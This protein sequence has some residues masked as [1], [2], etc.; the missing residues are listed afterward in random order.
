MASFH[1]AL[2]VA[3]WL[4]QLTPI[5]ALSSAVQQIKLFAHPKLGRVL[6]IGG[7]IQHVE[8]W[9]E[10]YHEPLVHVPASFIPEVRRA[11][12]LGGGSLFAAFEC[13]KYPTVEKV[14]LIDHDLEVIELVCRHYPHARAVRADPRFQLR[15]ADAAESLGSVAG[16][17]DLIINDCFDL[18]ADL[19]GSLSDT[20][21]KLSAHLSD[22]GLCSDVIYRHVFEA[23]QNRRS[24][25]ALA[26]SAYF[27][28]GLIVIPE[29]P[30]VL[31]I[32]TIWGRNSHVAKPGGT[33][34]NLLQQAHVR[35]DRSL[36]FAFYDPA[37]RRHFLHVPPYLATVVGLSE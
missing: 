18:F 26:S 21:A 27:N 4:D 3:L 12:V 13:L 33:I 7:E 19:P 35:G 25:L 8:A 37:F 6:V 2:D 29:Y 16:S 24:I 23:D 14:D 15:V 9:Q 11:L 20:Y 17:Y 1:E 34:Q 30:G 5:E 10:L 36:N 31:H 32:H 28:C 22:V